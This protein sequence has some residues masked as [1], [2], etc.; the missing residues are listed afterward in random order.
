MSHIDE[1]AIITNGIL[2]RNDSIY[3]IIDPLGYF[4]I[5]IGEEIIEEEEKGGGGALDHS[6]EHPWEKERKR[7]KKKIITI[8]VFSSENN[9]DYKES[10]EVKDVDV[11]IKKVQLIEGHIHLTLYNPRLDEETTQV[12]KIKN[13]KE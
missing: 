3:R 8:T 6:F 7:K 12:I 2:T 13:I 5:Q 9:I 1:F 10:I 4:V 11:K